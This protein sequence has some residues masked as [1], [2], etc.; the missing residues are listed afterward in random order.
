M[1]VAKAESCPS[2]RRLRGRCRAAIAAV[3]LVAGALS[4][5]ASAAADATAVRVEEGRLLIRS[6]SKS[7]IALLSE[8]GDRR[9]Q[10]ATFRTL[11]A[12]YFDVPR[13]ARFVLGRAA[14][15]KA[16]A[17]E[18][19]Q[20]LDVFQRYVA[21]VY[22]VKLR[23]YSGGK[24][25]IVA[26]RPDRK[27]VA[28]TSRVVGPR[29]ERPFYLKWR[30]RSS[31]GRLKVRDLVFENVSLSINQRR[32]FASVYRRYGGTM[33]GL[34]GAMRKKIAELDKQ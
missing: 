33:A 28:V 9:D 4:P 20:F 3:L 13:V 1:T 26:A 29:S 34:L 12:V 2:N 30:L 23:R 22:T 5:G 19:A 15:S 17:D 21:K 6:F 8:K 18:R 25:E 32:E 14:W 11:F 31:G 10:E 24:F 27:G 7:V 16:T